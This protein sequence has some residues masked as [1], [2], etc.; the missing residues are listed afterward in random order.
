MT[1]TV[2]LAVFRLRVFNMSKAEK[3]IRADPLPGTL[4]VNI[5]D[6]K[7][8]NKISNFFKKNIFGKGR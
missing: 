3:G 5:Q 6:N 1:V 4:A 7:E 8:F 2:L